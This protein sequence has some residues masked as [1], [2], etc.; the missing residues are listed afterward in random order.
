M[1]KP[2]R[3]TIAKRLSVGLLMALTSLAP[4]AGAPQPGQPGGDPALFG[5]WRNPDESVTV[6]IN[7][8]GEQVCGT[9]IAANAEAISDARDSGYPNLV[10]MTLMRGSLFGRAKVWRGTVLVPDLAR[11][12]AAH[13]ELTD[14][15]HARITGCMWHGL[16]CRSQ[17]WRRV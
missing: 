10:G 15:N 8:C 14:P 11:S 6:R 2:K 7:P 9:V 1:H 16:L 12:F 17:T 5:S 13:I 3:S 4:A